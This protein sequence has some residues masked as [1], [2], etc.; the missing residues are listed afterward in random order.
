MAQQI[1]CDF[2]V[3]LIDERLGKRMTKYMSIHVG[4]QFATNIAQRRLE[5]GV[6][7]RRS[8]PFAKTDPER[9]R[10]KISRPFSREV[11]MVQWPGDYLIT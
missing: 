10:R 3:P 2:E 6:G 8:L 5:G 4:T 7:Q 11:M 1:L 9:R